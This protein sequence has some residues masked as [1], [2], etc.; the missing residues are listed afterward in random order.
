M[1]DF[2]IITSPKATYSE[3]A[4]YYFRKKFTFERPKS[5]KIHITADSRYKL[6]IN[7][8]MASFGPYKGTQH[9]QY[10][11]TV[12]I[13]EFLK[14]GE[15]EFFAEVLQLASDKDVMRHHFLSSVPRTG[16]LA[17]LLWGFVQCAEERIEIK[18]DGSWECAKEENMQFIV[19]DYAYYTG[20]GEHLTYGKKLEW[21]P[22]KKIM[23]KND[24]L[25]YGETKLWHLKG[26]EM[27]AQS[28]ELKKLDR[29]DAAG[30]YDFGRIVT[31]F[32]RIRARGKGTLKL[33]YAECYVFEENKEEIKRDRTDVSGEIRGDYDIIEIEGDKT[34]ETFWFRTFRFIKVE[35]DVELEELAV[36]ETGYPLKVKEDY[37]FGNETDNTLWKICVN[38][39][40]CC[41]HETYEDCPY[42]EQLQYA[43]DAYLQ[44]LFTM[45]LTEDCTLVKRGINDF[46][47]SLTAGDICQSRFPSAVPQYITGFSLYFIYMLDALERNR[48]EREFIKKYLGTVDSIFSAFEEMKRSDGLIGKNKYWNFIDWAAGWEEGCGVPESEEGDAFTVYNLMYAHA[49]ELAARLCRIFG[50]NSTAAEYEKTAEE[51]KMLVKKQCYCE[52][53]G[54]YADTDRKKTFSQHAQIW[55]VLCRLDDIETGKRLMKKSVSLT[56]KGGFAYAYF[57]FRAFEAVGEYELTEDLMCRYRQLIEQNCTTIP[58]TPDNPRSECH[59]WGAV[60][61]YEF[62]T[63]ILGVKDGEEEVLVKPYRKGRNRASG[64][65]FTKWGAVYVNWSISDGIFKI[66]ITAEDNVKIRAELPGNTAV[67]GQGKVEAE[68]KIEW[69]KNEVSE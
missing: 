45:K 35:G 46:A 34:H 11:N 47:S 19:P 60:S 6:W 15:N 66:E 65:V 51:T 67:T 48:G 61:I 25:F 3:D 2:W 1:Q 38:T 22:S 4:L 7:G 64:T 55:A 42:Y 33:T 14:S 5:A 37:E 18:T 54:L 69:M 27:P 57:V 40:K 63:V 28:Y 17:F 31:G 59:G 36:A 56:A 23:E 50:R 12:D 20:I 53:T 68:C 62:T 21:L 13:T 30:N 16:N 43:M 9:N 24:I 39:L 8:K 44:M 29:K 41:M 58:E 49:L 26:H 10:Y 32:V 52:K